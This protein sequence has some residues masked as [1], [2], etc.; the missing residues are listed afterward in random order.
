MGNISNAF[1]KE[2][3]LT[4][5]P[6][7]IIHSQH[8]NTQNIYLYCM[9]ACLP[10]HWSICLYFPSSFYTFL[11]LYACLLSFLLLVCLPVL[12]PSGVN[13]HPFICPFVV[14]F[15]TYCTTALSPLNSYVA[16]NY[17]RQTDNLEHFEAEFCLTK[18]VLSFQYYK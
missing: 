4:I 18:C 15:Y 17:H 5:T 9:S 7:F 2:N 1:I 6:S 13:V 14:H 3:Q 16:L 10:V 11:C 8:C 12:I